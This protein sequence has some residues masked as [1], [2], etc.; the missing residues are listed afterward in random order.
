MSTEVWFRNPDL[1]IR[2]LVEC[3]EYRIAWD[4]GLLVKKH[5]DPVKHAELYYGKSYPYRILLVGEQGTAEIRPGDSVEK[6]S[7]VYPT[8]SYGDDAN[9]LEEI[10]ARPVGAD[11]ALCSD[12]RVPPDERPVLGQEHRVVITDMPLSHS[13]PGRNFLRY[14]KELQESYPEAIIHVHGLYSFKVAFGMGFGAADFE[15]RSAAA[16]GKVHLP[17]GQEAKYETAAANPKWITA[18]GFMPKDLQVPRNRCMFNIKSAVWAGANYNALFNFRTQRTGQEVDHS[19]P[20]S[21]FQPAT[22]K[23]PFTKAVTVKAGDKFQCNTCSLSASCK[24]FREGAVCSVPGAEPVELARLFQSRDAGLIID[25]LGTLLAA[26][27]RRLERGMLEEDAIGDSNPEVTR[28]ISQ[29]F[30]QGIKLA[31]LIDP[32]LRAGPN[33]QVNVGGVGNASQVAAANPQQMV[34]AVFRELKAQGVAEEDITPEMVQGVLENMATHKQLP[35]AVQGE[36][37]ARQDS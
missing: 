34:A 37:I 9:I 17:S 1:Y 31:K 4:R 29:V 20:T 36:V 26:S 16:K 10:L 11:P 35:A 5:I 33:V 15:P 28:Q 32:S 25:G 14:L 21:E 19:S 24:Y 7:A 23:T 22:T 13:G 3:G 27:T 8:W 18:L 12:R 30:D 2:E 6:P